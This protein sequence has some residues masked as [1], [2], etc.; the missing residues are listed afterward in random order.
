M[1][2]V[3]E[4]AVVEVCKPGGVENT[5]SYRTRI[6]GQYTKQADERFQVKR[7]WFFA[8]R[9]S[10]CC[11]RT[12]GAL[13]LCRHKKNYFSLLWKFVAWTSSDSPE[14]MV[15]GCWSRSTDSPQPAAPLRGMRDHAGDRWGQ[16]GGS[17]AVSSVGCLW[18]RLQV[19]LQAFGSS[20]DKHLGFC[21]VSREQ[22]LSVIKEI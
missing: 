11:R 5:V 10:P 9:E 21:E 13:T 8:A 17:S 15:A 7:T 1:K 20:L 14:L 18:G 12:L 2:E 3:T 6:R 19:S 16:M 22:I 4:Q